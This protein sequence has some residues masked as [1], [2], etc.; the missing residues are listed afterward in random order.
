MFSDSLFQEKVQML[1]EISCY[2]LGKAH[3]MAVNI[4]LNPW[5]GI[6]ARKV[7]RELV[8]VYIHFHG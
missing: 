6:N 4:L 1:R 2:E 8:A 7:T 5:R 3:D